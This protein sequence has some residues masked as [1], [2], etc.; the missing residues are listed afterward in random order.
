MAKNWEKLPNKSSR[1]TTPKIVTDIKS[2]GLNLVARLVIFCLDFG[3]GK[4]SLRKKLHEIQ[5]RK[6]SLGFCQNLVLVTQCYPPA[7]KSLPPK[8]REPPHQS[9]QECEHSHRP[10]GLVVM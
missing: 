6:K 5:S 2:L 9:Q 8:R 1:C 4:F 7:R 3:F 10:L